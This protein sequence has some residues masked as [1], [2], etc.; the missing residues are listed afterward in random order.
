MK[1]DMPSEKEIRAE[2]DNIVV[3]GIG[4]RESFYSYLKNMY[5]Q[6]GVK[7]LFRDGIEI[8]FIILLVS[9]ILFSV[10]T[11]SYMEKIEEVY[12]CLFTISPILYLS[13][14]ILSFVNAKQNKTYEVEMTCKYNI[15]QISAFRM[16]VFSIL[17]I[18][19]NFFFVYIM[20]YYYENI[21]YL[22]AFIISVASLFLF[23]TIFLFAITKI[24]NISTK[25]FTVLGWIVFNLVLYI[26]KVEFYIQLL[27][28]I[29][30][31]TWLIVAMSSTVVYI[32]NLKTL[33]I[34]R[35][36]EGMI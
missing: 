26:F 33:I 22:K 30:I 16:L 28:S 27:N 36:M 20:V 34:F 19:F 15:Y 1:I 23:S 13:M 29:S 4:K 18:L 21:D 9:Y 3:E 10:V 7:H 17:C 31:Y 35:N 11:N 24:K 2:I 14:S 5:R 8:I 12:A 25:Y 32:K 6:I